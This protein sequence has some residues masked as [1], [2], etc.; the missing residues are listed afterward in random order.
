MGDLGHL[1][2]GPLYKEFQ[3]TFEYKMSSIAHVF[4]SVKGYKRNHKNFLLKNSFPKNNKEKNFTNNPDAREA[5]NAFSK[6]CIDHLCIIH[7]LNTI[8]GP[9]MRHLIFNY[10][11]SKTRKFFSSL[12]RAA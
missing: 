6:I 8:Y 4:W 12:S 10:R 2:L 1:Y 11:T 5:M 7:S 3:D 9:S